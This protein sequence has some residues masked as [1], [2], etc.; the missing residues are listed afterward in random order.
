MTRAEYRAARSAHRRA[1]RSHIVNTGYSLDGWSIKVD[2]LKN[3]IFFRHRTLADCLRFAREHGRS[4][5]WAHAL[6]GAISKRELR[7]QG[8]AI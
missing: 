3:S 7:L 1:D 8:Y 6:C 2:P 4:R 5:D